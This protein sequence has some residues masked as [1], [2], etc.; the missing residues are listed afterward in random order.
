MIAAIIFC[1]IGLA[2]VVWR[3]PI[4]NTLLRIQL[5]QMKWIFGSILDLDKPWVPVF[6]TWFVAFGGAIFLITAILV[7][8]SVLTK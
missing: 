1:L 3:K 5:P 7:T 8:L 6:Y 2:L 4:A